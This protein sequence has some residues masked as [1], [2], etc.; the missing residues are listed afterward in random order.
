MLLISSLAKLS[1]ALGDSTV[2]FWLPIKGVNIFNKHDKVPTEFQIIY[3]WLLPI[4]TGLR[5]GHHPAG[6]LHCGPF[7]LAL[8][9]MG[10][11]CAGPPD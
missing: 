2:S 10:V 8:V 5:S 6:L 11:V 4:A 1:P 3:H 7:H 9:H